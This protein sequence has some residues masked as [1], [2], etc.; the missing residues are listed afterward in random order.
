MLPTVSPQSS[1]TNAPDQQTST[2]KACSWVPIL[3]VFFVEYRDH[4]THVKEIQ[5]INCTGGIQWAWL[6]FGECLLHPS[7]IL[8]YWIGLFFSPLWIF[9]S[10]WFYH[11]LV[12]HH[13]SSKRVLNYLALTFI[14]NVISLAGAVF[15]M[16]IMLLIAFG[17]VTIVVDCVA[18]IATVVVMLETQRKI[19]KHNHR[20]TEVDNQPPEH[21][22]NPQ[23]SI[24]TPT[25]RGRC[26]QLGCF[27]FI[28]GLLLLM[29]VVI[30]SQLEPL[31]G[32]A[33]LG[34][35]STRPS[36]EFQSPSAAN[37]VHVTQELRLAG[38][39]LGCVACAGYIGVTVLG[40]R[41]ATLYR[42][43]RC[44]IPRIIVH[45]PGS[46]SPTSRP[47]RLSLGGPRMPGLDDISMES[48]DQRVRSWVSQ[49]TP[50]DELPPPPSLTLT[51]NLD[52]S[53][54]LSSPTSPVRDFES[55]F[56]LLQPDELTSSEGIG[57]WSMVGARLG[58][59]LSALTMVPR[60]N[61]L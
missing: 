27:L 23:P 30:S 26:C 5:Q 54:P 20:Y 38:Y 21:E 33:K 28:A 31:P 22:R 17:L 6:N 46:Q 59:T 1:A 42:D 7:H 10:L 4:N 53:T 29:F 49:H 32:P 8:G 11:S 40:A 58:H 60:K 34:M 41:L 36:Q 37:K 44:S 51:L 55:G 52:T 43:R 24:N 47:N 13:S 61:S 2:F 56:P 15:S 45:P 16:Q 18:L 48:H 35:Q 50:E 3:Q 12:S 14:T 57:P 39:V 19:S 9:G 25:S